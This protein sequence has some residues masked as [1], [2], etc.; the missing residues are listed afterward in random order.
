MTYEEESYTLDTLME[1]REFIRN[2]DIKQLIKETHENNMMLKYIMKV[3]NTYISTH[4]S[5]NQDDF[6]RNILANLI[7]NVIDLGGLVK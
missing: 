3:L 5:E 2:K 4:N 6:N 1:I 7:S